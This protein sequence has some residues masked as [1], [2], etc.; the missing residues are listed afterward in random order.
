MGAASE[1]LGVFTGLIKAIGTYQPGSD[2][3]VVLEWCEVIP[4]LTLQELE[5]ACATV[6]ADDVSYTALAR[7]FVLL[8]GAELNRFCNALVGIWN[9]CIPSDHCDEII[10]S[11]NVVVADGGSKRSSPRASKCFNNLSERGEGSAVPCNVWDFSY[12]HYFVV[13]LVPLA[14]WRLLTQ[15]C[16]ARVA[17]TGAVEEGC[18]IE[19]LLLTV[20]DAARSL[21]T[22]LRVPNSRK[23]RPVN[24]DSASDKK[25]GRGSSNV[26]TG[27]HVVQNL[28][29]PLAMSAKPGGAADNS[30]S[31]NAGSSKVYSFSCRHSDLP[32]D[33]LSWRHLTFFLT[34]LLSVYHATC[35]CVPECSLLFAVRFVHA[36]GFTLFHGI[37]L[38]C[39][40]LSEAKFSP[41]PRGE[42]GGEAAASSLSNEVEVE[43]DPTSYA[44]QP[45]EVLRPQKMPIPVDDQ[46][47]IVCAQVASSSLVGN[48]N[49]EFNF[50]R[51]ECVSCLETLLARAE[52]SILP[53]SS[54][55][56]LSVINVL[57]VDCAS[58]ATTASVQGP[59]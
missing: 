36:I 6:V 34:R 9:P 43:V 56:I 7:L 10:Q 50:F 32:L 37:D 27:E 48:S 45:A 19:Q 30:S 22:S 53:H 26:S 5:E 2:T 42:K 25:K 49:P 16:S 8:E 17:L 41:T 39:L 13:S 47:L 11:S 59:S 12:R 20:S 18:G 21:P 14:A 58:T 3:N 1:S 51:A 33:R 38:E 52:D 24:R 4:K 15:L 31:G 40:S 55:F 29:T 46:L 28:H 35:A 57:D 44:L 54:Y 23:N